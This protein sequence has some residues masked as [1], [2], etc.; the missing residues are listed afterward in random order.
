MASQKWIVEKAVAWLRKNPNLEAKDLQNK[1]SEVYSVEVSYGTAWAGRQKALDKIYGSW[2]D[3]FQSLFNFRA[4]LLA[5]SPRSIMEIDTICNGDNVHF[6]KL[7]VALQP[8]IDG[9]KNGCRPYVGIDSTALTGRYNGQLGATCALDGHN[10]MYPVAWGVIGSESKDN[11]TWFMSQFKKAIGHP[12]ALA[13]SSDACKGLD[14]AVKKIKN[15]K[16]LPIVDLVDRLRQMTME[17]WEKRRKIADKLSGNILPVI[18]SELKAKT[19]GLGHMRVCKN[20]HKAEIFGNYKDLTPWPHVVD[21]HEHT[22]SCRAWEVTGKPCCHALTFIQAGRNVDLG[23]FVHEYYS[24]ARF[25]VA[26]SGTIPTM[27]D[28][29]Q[30][31]NVNMGFK[32][33]PPKLKIGPGRK[34]K[35]R[36]KSSDELGARKLDKCETCGE[37][38]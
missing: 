2:D 16:D 23:S 8:C 21:L 5:N 15:I 1:F 29:S 13:I 3:S 7:F 19:K 36:F 27:T 24:V 32:L 18:I 30:W 35:N 12:P 4:E 38:G 22:C 33:L 10:W 31:P 9:F 11:W 37:V 14:G 26:Y 28:K 6:D 34:R 20:R 17:L 25:K